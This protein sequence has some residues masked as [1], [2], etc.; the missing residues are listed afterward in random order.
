MFFIG[1]I[2]LRRIRVDDNSGYANV[3]ARRREF[4][5]QI[6][7]QILSNDK[8]RDGHLAEPSAIGS[9]AATGGATE[10]LH[11]SAPL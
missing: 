7:D 6:Q 1:D 5:S 9:R 2:K 11:G 3:F 4:E 10:L 8:K